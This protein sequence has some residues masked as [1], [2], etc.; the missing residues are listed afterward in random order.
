MPVGKTGG[1]VVGLFP[2]RAVSP[3]PRD[4]GRDRARLWG[5]RNRRRTGVEGGGRQR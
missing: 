4:W 2:L 3:I 5:N 1:A